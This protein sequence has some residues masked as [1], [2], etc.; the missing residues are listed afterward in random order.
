M[1]MLFRAD[2]LDA[3]RNGGKTVLAFAIGSVGIVVGGATGTGAWGA[4]VV[5][6]MSSP[7]LSISQSSEITWAP[8][9]LGLG[10]IAWGPLEHRSVIRHM[11][12]S[13]KP[14]STPTLAW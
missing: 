8:G 14:A 6:G 12:V 9:P 7:Q 11:G 10:Q 2:V 13:N 3:I 4:M 5:M 1:M